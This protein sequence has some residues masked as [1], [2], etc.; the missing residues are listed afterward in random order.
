MDLRS[1]DRFL[2]VAEHGSLNRASEALNISQPALSKSI[3][4]FED[5]IGVPLINRS[6]KGVSLTSFGE[7]VVEHGRRIAEEIRRLE[8]DIEAI[9]T[10]SYG[11]INVGAPLGPDSRNLAFSILRLV[12]ENRRITI[13]IFN[14]TRDDLLRPLVLGQLDFMIANLFDPEELPPDLEQ[15]ALYED[16]MLLA[17]R[18]GHD[19]LQMN[20]LTLEHLRVYPWIALIGNRGV[21]EALRKL[22]GRDFNKS[23]LRS[24]SPMFVKNTLHRDDFVGFVRRDAVEIELKTG[25]LVEVDVSGIVDLS[26]I[27]PPQQVGLIYRS[28]MSLSTA[29]KALIAEIRKSSRG[30]DPAA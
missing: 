21:E 5:G 30:Q 1:L 14:G 13:N 15:S 24:G 18:A 10:L 29:S 19:V 6:P 28:T 20:E 12:S 3:Q 27:L 25:T 22:I 7:S 4:V 17:V 8:S 2:A 26:T 11:E 16:S 23:L 9:K